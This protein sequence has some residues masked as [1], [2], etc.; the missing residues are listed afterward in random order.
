MTYRVLITGSRNWP[1]YF[2]IYRALHAELL[3]ANASDSR[4]IVAHGGSGQADRFAADWC[5]FQ[6]SVTEDVWLADWRTH[7]RK[8]GPLRNTNMIEPGAIRCHAFILPCVLRQCAKKK[9][10]GT[11]GATD[12]ANK[13]EKAGIETVIYRWE[14]VVA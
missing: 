11:H 7:G 10:H 4:L 14:E 13:A 8:A 6:P 9:P 1:G 3:A 12:C 5:R 2:P